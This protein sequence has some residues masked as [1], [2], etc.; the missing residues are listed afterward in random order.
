MNS[1]MMWWGWFLV[2]AA[3]TLLMLFAV[4][5]LPPVKFALEWRFDKAEG[6]VRGWLYPGDTLP[7]MAAAAPARLPTAR[8]SPTPTATDSGQA[9]APA[10]APSPT[11]TPLPDHVQLAAPAWEK[12]DWNNCG[13]ATLA[14]QL[15]YFGWQGDQ[16]EISDLLKPDRGDKNVNI[17][18]LAYYVRTRA[19]WLNAEFRVGGDFASL[20]RLL[21]AGYPVMVEKGFLLDEN[22]GGGGWAGHYLLLTGY[23]RTE[24]LF[25]VQD[26][27]PTTGGADRVIGYQALDSGWREFN[28]VYLVLFLPQDQQE[29]E[30]LLGPDADLAENRQRAI[31]TARQEIEAGPED[32]YAWFNLGTNLVYFER[33]GE[34]AGAFDQA[35]S[36]GLPWRFTRYQFGP[37]LAYFHMGRHED[38]IEL[39]DATLYRTSKAEESLLWRG[40]ARMQ[41]GDRNG[42]A[43]DF[44]AALG[45]NPNY[46]DAQYALDYLLS[47]G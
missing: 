15:R 23:D 7:S 20:E 33:Y 39:A 43:A 9:A 10:A 29:I 37:Y 35:L 2:G 6:I 27:N 32:A 18:E 3:A 21:A 38:V 36:L 30:A 16:F 17:D 8:P 24:R 1:R 45:V 26:T 47:G 12:Q 25:T 13:P 28:R 14:L 34:A 19:G 22:D 40:W 5:Q 4:Y 31:E 41:Q 46:L 44:R 42:A 11:S